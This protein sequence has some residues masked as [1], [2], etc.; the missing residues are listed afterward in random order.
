M[1]IALTQTLEAYFATS[2]IVSL[3]EVV[4]I[5]LNLEAKILN[6]NAAVNM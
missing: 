6:S 3:R 1:P 5:G 4:R 2:G